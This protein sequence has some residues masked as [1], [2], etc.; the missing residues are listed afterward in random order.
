METK[1]MTTERKNLGLEF[2][3]K[4]V[5]DN[6]TFAGYGSVFGNK[7]LWG[8]I[9][10]PGAFEKSIAK[11]TPVMLWQHNT[12]EPIGVYTKV[13][14]RPKGLYVEGKLLIE[15]VVRSKEAHAL[16]KNGAI[17]GL[18]IGFNAISWE[19]K[20][21]DGKRFRVLNEIDLW[22]ISLVTFPANEKALVQNV[23]NA[24]DEIDPEIITQAKSLLA[25]MKG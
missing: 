2:E 3:V 16:L 10:M 12:D 13:E 22:E 5:S 23:K 6:G 21:E 1:T 20:G 19:N 14:E 8:D 11:K 15:D 25:M 7:D 17:R 24:I 4:E 18:S 9:V